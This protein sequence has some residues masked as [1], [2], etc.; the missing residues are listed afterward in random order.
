MNQSNPLDKDME[1]YNWFK[2]YEPKDVPDMLE[3]PVVLTYC[4]GGGYGVGRFS[5][6]VSNDYA[7]DKDNIV[8]AKTTTVVIIDKST[9]IRQKALD[10]LNNTLKEIQAKAWKETEEVKARI[11]QLTL[12]EYKPSDSISTVNPWDN[13]VGTSEDAVADQ[14]R[15]DDPTADDEIP[16]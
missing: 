10:S 13:Q 3:I 11:E 8:V 7:G 1:K 4:I 6:H 14:R 9:D 16:L 5:V 12:L 2:S 15:Q